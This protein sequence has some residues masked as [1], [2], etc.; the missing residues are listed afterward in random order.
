MPLDLILMGPPGAGKGTQAQRLVERLEMDHIATGDMLRAAV[1][2]GTPLGL[3]AKEIMARGDL[4][5]DDVIIGLIRDRLA[6]DD[7][8]HGFCSTASRARRPQA[9]ELDSMLK[10]LHRGISQVL[11]FDV[12]LEA[13]GAPAFR[14]PGMPR[15]RARLPPRQ[16]AAGQRQ[17]VRH[18]RLGAVPARGRQ[19][20]GDPRPLPEA[21]ERG[22]RAG[23][24]LLPR[25]RPG[26]RRRCGQAGRSGRRRGRRDHR[27][28]GARHDHPQV[29]P[30]GRD[31]GARRRGGGRDAHAA[32]ARG[33]A[34]RNARRARRDGRGSHPQP[35]RCAVV[36]GLPRLPRIDLRVAQRDGGA[37]HP[38]ARTR[39]SP[40]I[41]CR[42]M[43]A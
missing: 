21:V 37:R 20:R 1:R 8:S 16:Q 17:R 19:A 36:Q 15:G 4:V 40:A 42:S 35:G 38:R 14:S 30:R 24:R 43:W 25:A 6:N 39:S 7:T 34:R 12:D 33:S 26:D 11:A 32:R 23:A 10:T 28:A 27:E 9:A 29:R 2:E 18:R 31:D 5:P 3:Q 13:A 41:C 22:G